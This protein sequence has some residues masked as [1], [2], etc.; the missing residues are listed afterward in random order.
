MTQQ[1]EHHPE[2]FSRRSF[3]RQA[4]LGA[5]AVAGIVHLA[6]AGDEA[7]PASSKVGFPVVDYHVHLSRG[8]PIDKAAELANTRGVKFGIVEH[9]SPEGKLADDNALRQYLDMLQKYPVYRGVQPVYPNW[10]KAFSKEL[11]GQLDYILM[12]A[13]TL[14][15]KDGRWLAIWRPETAVPDRQA[16]MTRYMEFIQ[17]VLTEEPID[18]FAW[19]TYLPTCISQDYDT[20]WT[21]ERMH[22]IVE[23][24]VKQ[25]IA[26]EL[27]EFAQV[28]KPRFVTMAKEAGLKFTFGT[29]S[30]DTRAGKFDYCLQMA[31]QCG[32]TAKHM[33]TPKPDSQKAVQKLPKT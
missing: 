32:L 18:I 22:Q 12:D 14:P 28:P 30:R 27:N 29:D 4:T 7:R 23:L 11:L 6:G 8:L 31:R 21:D 16:F 25:D 3:L 13:L 15:E 9:P 26:I 1:H 5:T 17:R 20:L 2:G 19:P 24:A 33:F 10:A